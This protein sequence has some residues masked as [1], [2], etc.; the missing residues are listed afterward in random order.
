[1]SLLYIYR[2]VKHVILWIF[3]MDIDHA[4]EAEHYWY[5]KTPLK[6]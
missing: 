5:S 4:Y 2:M 6:R 3:T 1:M